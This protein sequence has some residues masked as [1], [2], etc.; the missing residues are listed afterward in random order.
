MCNGEATNINRVGFGETRSGLELTIY[1]TRGEHPNHYISDEYP[2]LNSMQ[3]SKCSKSLYS[4][5]ALV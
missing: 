5:V 1:C 2:E 3:N 4:I